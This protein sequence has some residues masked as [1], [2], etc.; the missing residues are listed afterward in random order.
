[1]TVSVCTKVIS[2][3][4]LHSPKFRWVKPVRM[5]SS[6]A[7]RSHGRVVALD[8]N[9][10][11]TLAA[12][13]TG[14]RLE[15]ASLHNIRFS[16]SGRSAGWPSRLARQ[17]TFG[18]VQVRPD[19]SFFEGK[20]GTHSAVA[21]GVVTSCSTE[22]FR[23]AAEAKGRAADIERASLVARGGVDS[24]LGLCIAVAM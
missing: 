6:G 1:M 17:G 2:A 13:Y 18:R 21:I 24:A 3:Y 22:F 4:A 11:S 9:S 16:S 10:V 8:R 15:H 14:H 23:S 5:R 19:F 7:R 12:Y 20:A